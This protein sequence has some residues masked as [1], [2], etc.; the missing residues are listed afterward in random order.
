M[1]KVT[2]WPALNGG[3]GTSNMAN[4]KIPISTLRDTCMYARCWKTEEVL[5]FVR[6]RQINLR[7]GEQCQAERVGA[8]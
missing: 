4:V 3:E 5:V 7:G 2:P 8:R 1:L 6:S